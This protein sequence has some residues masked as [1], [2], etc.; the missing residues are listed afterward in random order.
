M[1]KE[2]VFVTGNKISSGCV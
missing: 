1:G 2:I